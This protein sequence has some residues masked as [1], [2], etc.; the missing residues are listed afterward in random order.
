MLGWDDFAKRQWNRNDKVRKC[1]HCV[2]TVEEEETNDAPKQKEERKG[3]DSNTSATLEESLS[4]AEEVSPVSPLT[5]TQSCKMNKVGVKYSHTQS[6]RNCSKCKKDCEWNQFSK[7]QWT[8]TATARRCNLCLEEDRIA[9]LKAKDEGA[10]T[11]L[12]LSVK[13]S[14]NNV[15]SEHVDPQQ[16]EPEQ[17]S[18]EP[19]HYHQPEQDSLSRIVPKATTSEVKDISKLTSD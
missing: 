11:L 5:N 15:E 14:V 13:A 7:T 1:K 12:G 2:K 3:S 4:R 10:Q 9:R 16:H 19:D 17:V 6:T 18:S 8:T